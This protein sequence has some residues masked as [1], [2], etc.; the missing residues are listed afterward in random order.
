VGSDTAD[1]AFDSVATRL[2]ETNLIVSAMNKP[3]P[4]EKAIVLKG[5]QAVMN[6]ENSN[7]ETI[8]RIG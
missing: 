1:V 5:V 4:T 3:T 6:C 2:E 7:A 8:F